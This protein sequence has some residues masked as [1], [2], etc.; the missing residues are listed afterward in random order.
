[1]KATNGKAPY[2]IFTDYVTLPCSEVQFAYF[3]QDDEVKSRDKL[4]KEPKDTACD[5]FH[6]VDTLSFAPG[7]GNDTVEPL[8]IMEQWYRW[9][10]LSVLIWDSAVVTYFPNGLLKSCQTINQACAEN[11]AN[12]LNISS[13]QFGIPS[14]YCRVQNNDSTI[15]KPLLAWMVALVVMAVAFV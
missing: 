10:N 6:Y 3:I 2:C 1:M 7:I 5:S 15:M 8:F 12:G 4:D 14:N 9:C 13:I 11:C